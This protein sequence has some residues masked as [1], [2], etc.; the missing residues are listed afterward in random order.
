VTPTNDLGSKN[1]SKPPAAIILGAGYEDNDVAAMRKACTEA[2][3]HHV[4]WLQPDTSK[5]SP[6]LGPEYGKAMVERLKVLLG[7][8]KGEG[9]LGSGVEGVF[10]F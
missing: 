2:Q 1:Y 3:A 4:P 6:P 9:K 5:P 7:E 8:L 10:R